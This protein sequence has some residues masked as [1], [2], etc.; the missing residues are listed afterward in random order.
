MLILFKSVQMMNFFHLKFTIQSRVNK[1]LRFFNI[2]SN[3]VINGL[4]YGKFEFSDLNKMIKNSFGSYFSSYKSLNIESSKF[5]NFNIN[6][7]K[8]LLRALSESIIIDDNSFFRGK[9]S[10]NA[11]VRPFNLIFP[12]SSMKAMFFLN[13]LDIG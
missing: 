10:A 3:D 5:V 8:K 12:T 7:K 13:K 9:L 2:I 6:F 4:I 1:D 11:N